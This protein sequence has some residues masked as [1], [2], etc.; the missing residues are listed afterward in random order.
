M[1]D[2]VV[3]KPSKR[4]SKRRSQEEGLEHKDENRKSSLVR[5]SQ[6]KKIE[7]RPMDDEDYTQDEFD[8]AEAKV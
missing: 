2:E 6:K 3:H 5:Q 4:V 7:Q 1:D 8:A